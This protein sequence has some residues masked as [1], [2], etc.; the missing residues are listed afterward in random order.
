MTTYYG[1][2][3]PTTTMQNSVPLC[4]DTWTMTT[5][6]GLCWLEATEDNIFKVSE[7]PSAIEL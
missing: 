2:H 7:R 4:L 5:Y 6:N 1:L 3:S